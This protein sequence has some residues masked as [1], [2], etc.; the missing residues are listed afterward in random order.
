MTFIGLIFYNLIFIVEKDV[1][2][3]RLFVFQKGVIGM[4]KSKEVTLGLLNGM[5]KMLTKDDYDLMYD[6]VCKLP[7]KLG[8]PMA[9][10]FLSYG[11]MKP[12]V[13]IK[14]LLECFELYKKYFQNIKAENGI[15][16]VV[17]A[18]ETIKATFTNAEE[19]AYATR[20]LA[21]FIDEI[22][23]A[24]EETKADAEQTA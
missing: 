12:D 21:V 24:C 23:M 18:A 19:Q 20:V 15:A 17:E 2:K 1:P 22:E 11:Y 14:V 3:V 8:D 5:Y 7:Q 6:T 9:R 13:T 10:T 4:M 16:D